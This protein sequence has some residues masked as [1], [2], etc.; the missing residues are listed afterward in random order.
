[1]SDLPVTAFEKAPSQA[2]HPAPMRYALGASA[3]ERLG[4]V[5][6]ALLCLWGLVYW[7]LR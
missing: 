6:V 3:F 7:A 1:M 4:P 2:D 5:L